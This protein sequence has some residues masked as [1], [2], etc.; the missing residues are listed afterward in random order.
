MRIRIPHALLAAA[1]VTGAIVA[2]PVLAQELPVT[3]IVSS[4]RATPDKAGTPQHPQGVSIAAKAEL[5]T[6]RDVDP[7][8]VSRVEILVGKGLVWNEGR[9]ATCSKQV[10]DRQGPGGCPPTSLM[11]SATATGMA[12]T[13]AARL[14]LLFFNGGKHRKYAYA[15]LNNPA[16]VRETL[17]VDSST[18]SGGPWAHRETVSVPRSLQIVAGIPL[19]LT[20]VRL[21]IGGKPYAK[22]FITSTSCPAGGWT[23]KVTT[24]YLQDSPDQPANTVNTGSIPCKK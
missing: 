3:R 8:I 21:K 9:Y 2:V 6:P 13:V 17:V 24:D 12:D 5:I 4:A 23:Y 16:R 18:P 22:K 14:D 11:G 20:R 10:L 15:T 1:L 19:R 7:P